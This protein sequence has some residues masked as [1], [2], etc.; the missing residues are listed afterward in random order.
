MKRGRKRN[1]ETVKMSNIST[2]N[3]FL[4]FVKKCPSAF[5]TV[6]TARERL[7]ENGYTELFEG[8]EWEL[9]DGGKYFVTKNLSSIVAFRYNAKGE[10]FTVTAS[11]SDF[12]SFRVKPSGADNG[13][14]Y[15]RLSTER[16]GGMINYSWLDRPLSV[17]G[18]VVVKEGDSLVQR[19][20]NVDKDLLVIPSV[21]IH[22]N[23]TV[24]EK[25][26][27]NPAIDLIPLMGN[28]DCSGFGDILAKALGVSA[29][30][31][32]SHDLFLYVRDEG[33]VFGIDGEFIVS[34]RIDNL[35]SAF[36]TLEAFLTSSEKNTTPVFAVFDNEEVGSDTKQG[37]ASHFFSDI[38]ERVA[39]GGKE[40]SKAIAK[41]FMVS[42]DNAHA[43]HPNHPE[44]SDVNNAPVMNKGVAIK[45]NA[46]QKYTTDSVSA[47]IFKTVAERCGESVQAFANRSDMPGGS[48]LGSIANTKFSV[49]TVDV[50]IPQIAMHSA[51][52]VAGVKD[53]ESLVN[54]L[55]ELYS[56]EIV[57]DKR[58]ISVK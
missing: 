12:P 44:L 26:C 41:S 4:S 39:G 18:R 7:I 47:A 52:E 40:L 6:D 15:T 8:D 3:N 32:V 45:Y 11:H 27:A 43:I 17:A 50:G 25:F 10:G 21:A 33:K 48:T 13:G 35:A 49:A 1:G 22:L 9:S 56:S 14:K 58:T 54:I 36:G 23:R 5:H 28:A 34:P 46:N 29:E 55:R 2:A 20:V 19:L 38:L 42:V 51:V 57:F 37:A 24:N 31:I 16:Y 30:D 53:L